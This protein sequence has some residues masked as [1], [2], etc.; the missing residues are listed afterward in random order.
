MYTRAHTS[1][2]TFSPKKRQKKTNSHHS[3]PIGRGRLTKFQTKRSFSLQL[4]M[5]FPIFFMLNWYKYSYVKKIKTFFYKRK[6]VQNPFHSKKIC[7]H[8]RSPFLCCIYCFSLWVCIWRQF[9]SLFPNRK[10]F[11][12]TYAY[13]T[14]DGF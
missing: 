6:T 11:T 2:P 1:A 5:Q 4:N 8:S 12:Q 14:E 10:H 13:S 7:W 9:C 3:S